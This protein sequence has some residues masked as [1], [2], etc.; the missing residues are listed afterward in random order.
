MVSKRP[1]IDLLREVF[2]ELDGRL[3]YRGRPIQHFPDSHRC[4]VWNA[5]YAGKESGVI[6]TSNRGE[7]RCKITLRP[8][9]M[10][11][12]Q[13]VWALHTSAWP[14]LLDHRD[15]DTL[16]DR[17]GNLRPATVAQNGANARAHRDN[18]CGT[19]GV[20]YRADR[21][22]WLAKI[23]SCGRT[24]YI[25]SYQTMDE[26]AAAYDQYAIHL[27]G[28]FVRPHHADHRFGCTG[29]NDLGQVGVVQS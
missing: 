21:G 22:V 24:F 20:H 8:F 25:G 3:F 27:N 11:R 7:K 6:Q 4:N 16:N 26:A 17:I 2:F 19:K 5:K 15:G 18:P 1:S 9:T 29:S 14:P 10:R 23:R 13:V 12:Y 28:E